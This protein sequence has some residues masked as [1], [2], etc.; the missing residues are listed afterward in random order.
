MFNIFEPKKE[1]EPE[2]SEILNLKDRLIL[3]KYK[4]IE[5]IG[6]EKD[7]TIDISVAIHIKG[8]KQRAKQILKHFGV[9]ETQTFRNSLSEEKEHE[10]G[11]EP[12]TTVFY[13]G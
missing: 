11:G 9:N 1:S 6:L 5:E 12:E 8:D 10:Y 3:L 7:E 13:N 4:I 2:V